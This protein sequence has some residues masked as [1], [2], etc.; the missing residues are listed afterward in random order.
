MA[1][2]VCPGHTI[3]KPLLLFSGIGESVR[4]ECASL[5]T[6]AVIRLI[7]WLACCLSN[8]QFVPLH[9]LTGLPAEL[10]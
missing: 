7:V 2:L 3:A 1:N 10:C 8:W 5:S 4:V 6:P 9:P